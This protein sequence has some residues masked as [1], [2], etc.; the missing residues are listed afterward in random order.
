MLPLI[1]G[2]AKHQTILHPDTAPGKMQ[3]GINKLSRKIADLTGGAQ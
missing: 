3:S 1:I 2:A